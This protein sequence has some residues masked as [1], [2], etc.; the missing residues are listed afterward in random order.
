MGDTMIYTES[1]K[2]NKNEALNRLKNVLKAIETNDKSIN[3]YSLIDNNC[4][5]EV[6]YIL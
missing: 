1:Q 3:G 2:F 6:N 5:H 4:E